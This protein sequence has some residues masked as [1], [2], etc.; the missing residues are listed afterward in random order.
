MAPAGDVLDVEMF[1]QG[2]SV[3]GAEDREVTF[4]PQMLK[5]EFNNYWKKTQNCC[6]DLWPEIED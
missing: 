3:W 1:Y 6:E 2:E 4:S 5:G